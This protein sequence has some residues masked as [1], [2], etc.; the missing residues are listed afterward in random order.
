MPCI[1]VHMDGMSLLHARPGDG[2]FFTKLGQG[3]LHTRAKSRNH[4]IRGAQKNCQKANLKDT[5]EIM[6]GGHGP[7]SVVW[8]HMWLGTQPNVQS[9]NFYSCMILTHD[10][11][12]KKSTVVKFWSAMVSRLC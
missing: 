10:K 6:Y 2:H 1:Y 5:S 9:M 12:F 11:I 7:S 8:S 3:P 4:E